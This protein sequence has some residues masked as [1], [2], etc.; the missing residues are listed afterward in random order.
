MAGALVTHQRWRGQQGDIDGDSSAL[1]QTPCRAR[2]AELPQCLH[3]H[4]CRYPRLNRTEASGPARA[5]KPYSNLTT[6][7]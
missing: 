2:L 7:F 4:P 5:C 1:A 3:N 6:P